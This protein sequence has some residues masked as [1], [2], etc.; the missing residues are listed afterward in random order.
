MAI[1]LLE[2][3]RK[4]LPHTQL[5]LA[6]FDVDGTLVQGLSKI[7]P[8]VQEAI[9]TLH[10]RGV[11]VALATGRPYFGAQNVIDLL[12]IKDASMFF[13]GSY[14]IEPGAEKPISASYLDNAR[15]V[16]ITEV[17]L[18]EGFYTE[19]YTAGDYYVDKLC[20]WSDIHQ[21]YLF[22]EPC[23]DDLIDIAE[24]KQILKLV[25]MVSTG[26]E[27]E[28]L[29]ER[30]ATFDDVSVT[31]GFG[32]AHHQIVFA[33][34][35]SKAATRESIFDL[36]LKHYGVSAAEVAAFGD[37]EADVPFLMRAGFGVAMGNAKSNVK[38]RAPYVTCSV[39]EDGVA[40]ALAK[41]LS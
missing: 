22:R 10:Q 34:V 19:L 28:K 15:T 33:N 30:L 29:R 39:E 7:S 8:A 16:E 18:R 11:R 1:N 31:Y 5:K 14:V 32:A 25:M 26:R 38:E 21:G 36:I 23:V 4:D 12:G 17:L 3:D 13:A 24:Q 2:T 37:S 35:T 41:L 27:E 40:K 20:S 9:Q 6:I